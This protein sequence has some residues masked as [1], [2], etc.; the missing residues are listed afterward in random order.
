[1]L[2]GL[3]PPP[4]YTGTRWENR[5]LALERLAQSCRISVTFGDSLPPSLPPLVLIALAQLR[6]LCS[7]GRN[8]LNQGQYHNCVL[9]LQ[10]VLQEWRRARKLMFA[11]RNY[12]LPLSLYTCYSSREGRKKPKR[13]EFGT[14]SLQ[15]LSIPRCKICKRQMNRLHI[16]FKNHQRRKQC[17][18]E[19]FMEIYWDVILIYKGKQCRY[20]RLY[21]V[22][23]GNKAC[24]VP[25][26]AGALWRSEPKAARKKGYWNAV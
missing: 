5:S 21:S 2:A 6:F 24:I 15:M 25:R 20:C 8:P 3:N 19:Y 7:A 14:E 23:A 1:M 26:C 16:L 11:R 4:W 22:S 18:N 10:T 9:C 12:L 13:N 17:M